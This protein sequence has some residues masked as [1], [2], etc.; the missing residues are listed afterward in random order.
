MSCIS[1]S[2]KSNGAIRL[3]VRSPL[4][5]GSIDGRRAGRRERLAGVRRHADAV[6]CENDV[7]RDP[8]DR[9]RRAERCRSI[10][11]AVDSGK[12]WRIELRTAEQQR[13][14]NRG[15]DIAADPHDLIDFLNRREPGGRR[16]GEQRRQRRLVFGSPPGN[17]AAA[18]SLKLRMLNAEAAAP[19]TFAPSGSK[20]AWIWI[21]MLLSSDAPHTSAAN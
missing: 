10:A 4:I 11:A 16:R 21:S 6:L 2:V 3:C 18:R 8:G 15:G 5:A 13:G 19:S 7:A 9:D 17:P 14:R 12:G 20:L 1:A